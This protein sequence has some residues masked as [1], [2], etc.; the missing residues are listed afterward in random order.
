VQKHYGVR[1]SHVTLQKMFRERW[2]RSATDLDSKSLVRSM[3]ADYP[4]NAI[5]RQWARDNM[6][7]TGEKTY[8]HKNI[9]T[10]SR[11]QTVHDPMF[12]EVLLD[13][14][15]PEETYTGLPPRLALTYMVC[16]ATTITLYLSLA[17]TD[18]EGTHAQD[19]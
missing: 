18:S 16:A 3:L 17:C 14:E 2:G 5:V 19:R 8:S 9:A 1:V 13:Q 7:L 6:L 11:Y 10:L 15:E 4:D 12:L